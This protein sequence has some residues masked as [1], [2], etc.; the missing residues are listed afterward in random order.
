MWLMEVKKEMEGKC[1][2]KTEEQRVSKEL[3]QEYI[4][5]NNSKQTQQQRQCMRLF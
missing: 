1:R 2:F 5:Q 3:E 4:E